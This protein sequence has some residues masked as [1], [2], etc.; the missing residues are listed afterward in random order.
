MSDDTKRDWTKY[1]QI[2]LTAV[3]GLATGGFGVGLA[4]ANQRRDVQDLQVKVQRLEVRASAAE[5][6]QS[7]MSLDVREVKTDVKWLVAQEKQR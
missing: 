3:V 4:Q 5:E 2:T 1:V 7:A 6:V